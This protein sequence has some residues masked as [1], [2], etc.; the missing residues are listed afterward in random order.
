MGLVSRGNTVKAGNMG[1]GHTYGLTEAL[2]PGIGM[3]IKSKEGEYIHGLTAGNLMGNGL[4]TICM[5]L[6]Y[7]LGRMEGDMRAS[8]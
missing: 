3:I 2:T 7:I 8:T 4:T 6:E 1:S 5:V